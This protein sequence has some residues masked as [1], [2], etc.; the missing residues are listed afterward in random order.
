M[1][2]VV[3][4]VLAGVRPQGVQGMHGMQMAPFQVI[5]RNKTNS[6]WRRRNGKLKDIDPNIRK[7]GSVTVEDSRSPED[8][9]A[10]I[11]TTLTPRQRQHVDH[12]KDQYKGK[13]APRSVYRDVPTRAEI[14]EHSLD[15]NYSPKMAANAEALIDWALSHIPERGGKRASREKKRIARKGESDRLEQATRKNQIFHAK[16]RDRKLKEK[17]SLL[18]QRYHREAIRLYG[19]KGDNVVTA[20]T[21]S[22]AST[23][24]RK[25]F[26][27]NCSR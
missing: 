10:S 13:T 27:Q 8:I 23:F 7:D 12:L 21:P 3:S 26:N 24:W 15:A 20:E 5:A 4:S 18:A 25:S 14:K 16:R 2:R 11:D 17:H 22:S 6:S 9:A 1:R 19:E